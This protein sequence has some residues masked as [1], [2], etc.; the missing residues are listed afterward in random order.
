VVCGLTS[1]LQPGLVNV[2]ETVGRRGKCAIGTRPPGFRSLKLILAPRRMARPLSTGVV[3]LNGDEP[4]T[5]DQFRVES[6]E[7][8][9]QSCI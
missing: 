9:L 7:A 3:F 4:K 5:K 6:L 2:M 8:N 1:M